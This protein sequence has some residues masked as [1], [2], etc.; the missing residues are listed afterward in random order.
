MSRK[1]I[2]SNVFNL[3]TLQ[4]ALHG[5]ILLPIHYFSPTTFPYHVFPSLRFKLPLSET[6]SIHSSTLRQD[7]C[8]FAHSFRCHPKQADIVFHMLD[9]HFNHKYQDEEYEQSLPVR[10]NLC[11]AV[12]LE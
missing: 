9:N 6:V 4:T 5:N 12:P 10:R 7:E 2:Y 1:L 8:W 3:D 11:Q